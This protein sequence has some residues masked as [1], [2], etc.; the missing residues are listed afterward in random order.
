MSVGDNYMFATGEAAAPR[1]RLLEEVYGPTTRMLLDETGLRAGL[2][3][4]EVGCGVGHTACHLAAGVGPT[5]R[6]AAVDISADQLAVAKSNALRAGLHNIEFV[7]AGATNI[8]LETASVDIVY[9]RM[10]LSH[11][12]QSAEA[13]VEFKRLLKPGGILACEDLVAS[14]VFSNPASAIYNQLRVLAI[15]FGEKQGADYCIGLRL[16]QLVRSTGLEVQAV[17]TVQPAYFCG[18]E[19]RWWEYSVREASPVFLKAGYSA[20]LLETLL[21]DLQ[22]V[23]LDENTLIAQ[24]VMTQVLARRG[25]M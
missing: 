22:K 11:V 10:L 4:A 16:P 9:C 12:R 21:R 18:E 1:L 19:K 15:Q 23:A 24:P 3:V 17:R 5:G 25:P 6:V 20:E 13:L 2:H 8:S 7:E 14:S